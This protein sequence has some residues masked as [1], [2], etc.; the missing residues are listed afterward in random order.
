MSVR[1]TDETAYLTFTIQ[2]PSNTSYTTL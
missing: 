2:T 1:Y